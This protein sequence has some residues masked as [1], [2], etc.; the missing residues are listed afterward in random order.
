MGTLLRGIFTPGA[1]GVAGR[2][3]EVN[4]F[5]LNGS[6]LDHTGSSGIRQDGVHPERFDALVAFSSDGKTLRASDFAR[7]A[8]AFA[9]S[10]P[11]LRGT[12]T[13]TLEF[14]SILEIFGR[15]DEDGNPYFT[16]DD[17]RNLWVEGKLP[18]SWSPGSH[19]TGVL[20]VLGRA[21]QIGLQ[22]LFG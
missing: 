1:D 17:A 3:G 10:D 7:A 12:A 20:S 9:A 4:I 5:T 19:D 2:N 18:E 8:N 14:A 11:G 22:R 15:R 21:A 16:I 13:Q 6:S